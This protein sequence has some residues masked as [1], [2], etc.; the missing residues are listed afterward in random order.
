V[1]SNFQA[2]PVLGT[3]SSMQM[4]TNIFGRTSSN[5]KL[6]KELEQW[7]IKA[8]EIK[9]DFNDPKAKLGSGAF[10]DVWRV[11]LFCSSSQGEVCMFFV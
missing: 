8:K 2:T 11:H 3:I 6:D 5:E 4:S 9:I 7:E 1:S 10:G